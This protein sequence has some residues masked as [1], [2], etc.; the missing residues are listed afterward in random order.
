MHASP[1]SL[2]G[3]EKQ[4]TRKKERKKDIYIYI[5]KERKKEER[6]KEERKKDIQ[7]ER[8]KF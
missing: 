3:R 8:T 1:S 2:R 4:K 7:K 6:K 5:K